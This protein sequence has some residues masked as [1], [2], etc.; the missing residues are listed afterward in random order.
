MAE[1]RSA[2]HRLDAA[3]EMPLTTGWV[4]AWASG[5][6]DRAGDPTVVAHTGE[7]TPS[8]GWDPFG[9]LGFDSSSISSVPSASDLADIESSRPTDDFRQLAPDSAPDRRRRRPRAGRL[10]QRWIPEPLHEARIDPGPR[11]AWLISAVAAVAAIAAAVGVWLNTPTAQPIPAAELIAVGSETI[12]LEPTSSQSL[13]TSVPPAEILVSVTGKVNSPG[14]VRLVGDA[15]V[16]DAIAAAGGAQVGV[17][18][19]GLNLAARLGDGDSV[20]VGPADD[21]VPRQGVTP[22]SAGSGVPADPAAEDLGQINLNSADAAAL[23]ALPGVGPV[24]AA[25][26]LAWREQNGPFGSID[27]LQEVT[28]IGPARFATLAPLVTV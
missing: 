6:R 21:G 24:M 22:D 10:K 5:A 8:R 2:A 23:E 3:P 25:N 19:T 28:G 1:T 20:V 27:Q 26:I 17:D 9:A 13:P 16:A 18:L 4:P 14:L 11:G 12:S 7:S 15:R